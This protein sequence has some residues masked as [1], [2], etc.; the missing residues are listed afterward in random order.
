[1]ATSGAG[2]P[3]RAGDDGFVG[4]IETLPFGLLVFV[5]GTLLV[6]NAWAVIDAKLASAS[7]AHEAARV[8]VETVSGSDSGPAARAARAAAVEAI[9]G[10]GRD[11]D[12]MSFV[13]SPG[14]AATRCQAVEVTVGYRVPTLTLPLIGGFGQGFVVS[15]TDSELIDPFR[16][17][18][19]GR[20]PC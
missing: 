15:A 4:G 14:R 9:E 12:R 5:V 3:R 17:D 13:M 20:N 10:H 1:M 16:D 18:V 11:P 19:A 7:A 8:Y 6:A 2:R